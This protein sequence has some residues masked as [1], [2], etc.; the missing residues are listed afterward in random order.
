MRK[1]ILEYFNFTRSQRN[2]IIVLLIVISALIIVNQYLPT[3]DSK[4][5]LDFSTFEKELDSLNRIEDKLVFANV[6]KEQPAH[7][8]K[9]VNLF[10]FDPNT[11]SADSLILLGL[12][13]KQ[14]QVLVNYRHKGGQFY[15]AS[16][17]SKI[18][19][20]TKKQ[21][22]TLIPFVAIKKKS[23]PIRTVR[24]KKKVKS[25]LKPS[26][27]ERYTLEL[28]NASAFDIIRYLSVD[29][30]LAFRAVKYRNLL[31]GFSHQSQLNEV[32][33]FKNCVLDT[34]SV[35]IRIDTS[36]IKK[37]DINVVDFSQLLKHPY[38]NKFE[39]ESILSYRNV[40]GAYNDISELKSQKV[41]SV[42]TF[43]KIHSYFI[44]K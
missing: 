13:A 33:G 38:I 44:V 31:G 35:N 29:T 34:T 40:V 37:L 9:R 18:Y 10:S 32:Y 41:I 3:V 20:L 12:S 25:L 23:S 6:A 36:L 21:V 28:N 22:E 2:A 4:Y 14:T 17:I 30:I 1:F 16:D 8:V 39:A 27:A 5:S 11:V 15:A 19:G 43:E 26:T 42:A 7:V 24:Q